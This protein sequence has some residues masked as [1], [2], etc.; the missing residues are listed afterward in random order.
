MHLTLQFLGEKKDHDL[1]ELL[2]ILESLPPPPSILESDG[3]DFF[4]ARA[5]HILYLS[6]KDSPAL[7]NLHKILTEELLI[8]GHD[9]EKRRYQPHITLGRKVRLDLGLS[10]LPHPQGTLHV[11]SIALMHSKQDASGLHYTALA[12]IPIK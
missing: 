6:V 1:P 12:E 8:E 3:Y 7:T 11:T 10:T 4:T 9:V 2:N 5:G